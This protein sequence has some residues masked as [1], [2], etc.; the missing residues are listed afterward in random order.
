MKTT[1]VRCFSR[2]VLI[3]AGL[4][5]IPVALVAHEPKAKTPHEHASPDSA[6]GAWAAITQ[7]TTKLETF[8]T[9]KELGG[10]HDETDGMMSSLKIL[11]EKVTGLSAEKQKRFDAAVRQASTLAD[12]LHEAADGEEQ[13]KAES[14][15]KKLK[16]ALKL[17]EVQLPADVR[18]TAK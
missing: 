18:A 3:A 4:T 15:L 11:A 17:V 8:V 13:M 16:G 7:S 5:F 12:S 1:T 6:A 10:V 14:E 9:A 2:L